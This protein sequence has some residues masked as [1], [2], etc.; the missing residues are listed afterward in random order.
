MLTPQ[1]TRVVA[2]SVRLAAAGAAVAL[3]AACSTAPELSRT[4]RQRLAGEVTD[5]GTALAF[6]EGHLRELWVPCPL[7]E[8]PPRAARGLTALLPGLETA[9]VGR[10]RAEGRFRGE[11]SYG[12][13]DLRGAVVEADGTLWCRWHRIAP[14][15]APGAIARSL[16]RDPEARLVRLSFVQ[17]GGGPDRYRALLEP[18]FGATTVVELAPDGRVLDVRHRVAAELEFTAVRRD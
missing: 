2:L 10:G 18:R 12:S 11:S 1:P 5:R 16:A 14:D 15:D 17:G 6:E 4:D 13:D 9:A 3:A 8:V 7:H